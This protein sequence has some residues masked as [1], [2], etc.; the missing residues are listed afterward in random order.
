MYVIAH[1]KNIRKVENHDIE[2]LEVKNG[3]GSSDMET[4]QSYS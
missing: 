2:N 4:P 3:I 1:N